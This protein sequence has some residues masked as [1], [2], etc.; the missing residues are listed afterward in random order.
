MDPTYE[1]NKA[2]AHEAG[3]EVPTVSGAEHSGAEQAQLFIS[4]AGGPDI[5]GVWALE[6][7]SDMSDLVVSL[8]EDD[9]VSLRVTRATVDDLKRALEEI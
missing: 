9:L 6:Y 7:D 5:G 1:T 2:N 8:R 4:V 3:S